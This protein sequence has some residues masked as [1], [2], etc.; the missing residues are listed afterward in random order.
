MEFDTVI[1]VG[2]EEGSLPLSGSLTH[3][4]Y[5]GIPEVVNGTSIENSMKIIIEDSES[6]FFNEE[7]RLL[8]VAMT[9][10]RNRVYLTHRLKTVSGRRHIPNKPSTFLMDLPDNIVSKQKYYDN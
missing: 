7:R 5:S 4:K 2:L 10:A 6:E 8:Y 3:V 1:I 9:R